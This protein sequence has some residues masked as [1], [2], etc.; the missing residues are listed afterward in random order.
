MDAWV[1]LLISE[2]FEYMENINFIYGKTPDGRIVT[3]DGF[4][5]ESYASYSNEKGEWCVDIYF[6]SGQE[7]T[8]LAEDK[9]GEYIPIPDQLDYC[10]DPDP[11]ILAAPHLK[12]SVMCRKID[13]GSSFMF[14]PNSVEF[15]I[16]RAEG[17]E[18]DESDRDV[19]LH[20]ASGRAVTVRRDPELDDLDG[21]SLEIVIDECF[22]RYFK[23]ED[24]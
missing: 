23:D 8:L 21:E 12:Y 11:E 9:E 22:C 10:W 6:K 13:N 17:D 24:E 20:F 14:D 1:P 7:V 4:R 19:E 18:D 3:M 15:Y 16:T 2:Y 5:V